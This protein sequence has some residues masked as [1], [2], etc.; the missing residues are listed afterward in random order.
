MVFNVTNEFLLQ[1]AFIEVVLSSLTDEYPKY[2]RKHKELATL[3]M[4]AIAFLLG[5]P[6]T[7]QVRREGG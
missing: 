5:I 6:T 2:L 4:C 1:F 3:V 7:L